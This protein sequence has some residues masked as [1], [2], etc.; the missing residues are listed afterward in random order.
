MG[1]AARAKGNAMTDNHDNLAHQVRYG[2]D[3]VEYAKSRLEQYQVCVRSHL[4]SA[5]N[6]LR[7]ALGQLGAAPRGVEP[8]RNHNAE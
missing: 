7:E 4:N 8:Q 2:L 6:S 3:S 1:E 5:I